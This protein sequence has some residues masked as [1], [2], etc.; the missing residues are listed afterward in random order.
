KD[1]K[2]FP[3]LHP[4]IVWR[5]STEHSRD[6]GRAEIRAATTHS[7]GQLLR[8]AS[9]DRRDKK[10][11]NRDEKIDADT[12]HRGTPSSAN[13]AGRS[14]YQP[15]ER[16]AIRWKQQTKPGR[17]NPLPKTL[18]QDDPDPNRHHRQSEHAPKTRPPLCPNDLGRR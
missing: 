14:K 12:N 18:R 3:L 1:P 15:R 2:C 8:C 17:F 13:P 11:S 6:H 5:T 7:L 16:R 9:E 4:P 10:Q